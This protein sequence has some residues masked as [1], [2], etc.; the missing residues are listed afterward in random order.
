MI[1]EKIFTEMALAFAETKQETKGE[2]TRF[3]VANKKFASIRFC[4]NR[5]T[6]KLSI[7]DQEVFCSYNLA[8]M[9]PVPSAG[10]KHGWT[11]INLTN[12]PTEMCQDA[13][14][15]AYCNV[16]PARLAL[17]YAYKDL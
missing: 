5:A 3:M 9:Y 7:T 14:T 16:A 6:V 13:L 1:T 12:T 10:G 17:L 2:V 15:M 8:L 4:K 11:H